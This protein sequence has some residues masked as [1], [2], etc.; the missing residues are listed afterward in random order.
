[1]ETGLKYLSLAKTH[2]ISYQIGLLEKVRV[3]KQDL[4]IRSLLVIQYTCVL[5]DLTVRF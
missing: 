2:G 4:L 3:L 5:V 1:M